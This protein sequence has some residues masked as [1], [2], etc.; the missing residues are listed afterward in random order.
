MKFDKFEKMCKSVTSWFEKAKKPALL[1]PDYLL[2]CSMFSRPG[3]SAMDISA[4]IFMDLDTLGIP[5][6]LNTDGSPNLVK[7]VIYS[8]I[9]E[10]NEG[11]RMDEVI[12]SYLPP[13]SL[14]LTVIGN[15]ATNVVGTR[16]LG[17]PVC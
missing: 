1:V 8:C 15:K 4:K 16:I 3:T 14:N 12:Q 10:Y 13:G 6:G 7:A 5:G 9:K 17:I 2:Y 11:R